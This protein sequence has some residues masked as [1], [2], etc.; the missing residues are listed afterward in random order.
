MN[1]ILEDGQ[2]HAEEGDLI[3]ELFL[4]NLCLSIA[5]YFFCLFMIAGD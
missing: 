5:E 2:R 4:L 1:N 3:S